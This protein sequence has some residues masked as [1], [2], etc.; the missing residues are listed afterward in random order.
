MKNNKDKDKFLRLK[1]LSVNENLCMQSS[2]I[3]NHENFMKYFS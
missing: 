2:K 3:N 1:T